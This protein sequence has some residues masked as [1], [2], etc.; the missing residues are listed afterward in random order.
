M[1]L[2]H[3]E[4]RRSMVKVTAQISGNDIPIDGLPLKTI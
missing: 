2:L 1:N 3:L 4:V